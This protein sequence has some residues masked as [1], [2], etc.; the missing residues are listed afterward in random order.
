M[1]NVHFLL[2]QNKG[3]DDGEGGGVGGGETFIM[4]VNINRKRN[5]QQQKYPR[6]ILM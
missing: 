1:T 5:L 4:N 3:C 6:I 2:P